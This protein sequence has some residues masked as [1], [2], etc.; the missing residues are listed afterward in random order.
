MED[1]LSATEKALKVLKEGME[2]EKLHTCFSHA[3][4]S[5]RKALSKAPGCTHIHNCRSSVAPFSAVESSSAV[6]LRSELENG[7]HKVVTGAIPWRGAF[8]TS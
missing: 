7:R 3:V 5:A 2:G 1:G 8:P 4:D 6:P